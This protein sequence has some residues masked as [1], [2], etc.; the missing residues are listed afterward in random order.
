MAQNPPKLARRGL[1][2]A[3]YFNICDFKPIGT[4]TTFRSDD[5]FGLNRHI[6]GSVRFDR[7][8][9][10]NRY[11]KMSEGESYSFWKWIGVELKVP[12]PI[13]MF[14]GTSPAI[15]GMIRYDQFIGPDLE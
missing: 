7:Y 14:K 3:S 8:P 13:S 15:L 5:V 11:R 10:M 9:K 4:Y 6:L 2:V 1:K 12:V